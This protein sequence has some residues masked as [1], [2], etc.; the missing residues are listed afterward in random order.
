MTAAT[1]RQ[2]DGERIA[3]VTG[4]L[5]GI[6][7]ATTTSYLRDGYSVVLV[8]LAQ[9]ALDE[10][11]DA[12]RAEHPGRRVWAV[13]ADV[14][15]PDS[16]RTLA[17]EVAQAAGAI[18]ALALVAGINQNAAA[19]VAELDLDEWDRVQGVNLRG[20]FMMAKAFIPL[21]PHDAGASIVL[22]ASFWGRSGHAYYAAYCTSKAAVISLTQCLASELAGDGIRVNGV[23]PGNIDTRMHR[24][25][26][27]T[28]A[29]ERGITVQE[30]QDIEWSKI[31]LGKAGSPQSIADAAVFLSS[32]EASYITGTTLDVN[33]GVVFT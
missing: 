32:R 28:E 14:S 29:A 10:F 26:L 27:E 6:G 33:G 5:G 19:P 21:M 13:A 8:D 15:S 17:D 7:R 16:V 4:A 23:A 18:H 30:M 25:A 12:L 9:E 24:E 20:P 1:D 31:P 11:A 2:V 22:I 3:L